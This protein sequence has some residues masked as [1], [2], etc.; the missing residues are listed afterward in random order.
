MFVLLRELLLTIN[1]VACLQTKFDI[2]CF[3]Q[4][5]GNHLEGLLYYCHNEVLISF[6]QAHAIFLCL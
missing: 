5:R 3:L 1:L 6:F 4:A 2:L